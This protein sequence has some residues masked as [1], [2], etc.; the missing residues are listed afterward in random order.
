MEILSVTTERRDDV[1]VVRPE[2]EVDMSSAAQ[3]RSVALAALNE[4]L[5]GVELDLG[6]LTFLDSSGLGA[7]L[8]IWAEAGRRSVP[9]AITAIQEGP[10]RVI[11]AAGLAEVLLSAA[12][13]E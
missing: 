13:S 5:S 4:A 3:L 7:L 8:D 1:L 12:P 2:G 6:A 9:I 10:E 11:A